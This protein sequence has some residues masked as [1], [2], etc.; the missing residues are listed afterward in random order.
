MRTFCRYVLA[1]EWTECDEAANGRLAW[2]AL[3][4]KRYDLVVSDMDMPEMTG[5][6]SCA[7]FERRP[8][9]LI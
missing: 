7:A 3:Q 8:C 1:D 2:E 9:M 4:G 5:P 6:E